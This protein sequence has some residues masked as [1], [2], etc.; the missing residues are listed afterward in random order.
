M[1]I[2]GAG[3]E[4]PK[5]RLIDDEVFRC[6]VKVAPQL[7]AVAA[8]SEGGANS[9]GLGRIAEVVGEAPPGGIGICCQVHPEKDVH[10]AGGPK[11]PAHVIHL[12]NDLASELNLH[13]CAWRQ[14]PVLKVD[15]DV[16][17]AAGIKILEDPPSRIPRCHCLKDLRCHRNLVHEN[18][19]LPVP[20]LG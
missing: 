10:T 17:S 20:A 12:A 5:A 16:G 19:V 15:D 14:E 13:C 4:R 11:R 6:H 1:Q 3:H 8:W 18:T 7:E 2:G 9:F